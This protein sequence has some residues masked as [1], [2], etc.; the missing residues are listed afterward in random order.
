MNNQAATLGRDG[1][2]CNSR[3]KT[4]AVC[5]AI[6]GIT[7]TILARVVHRRLR[8][9]FNSVAIIQ[10]GKIVLSAE[11]R[12]KNGRWSASRFSFLRRRVPAALPIFRRSGDSQMTN[13][14]LRC[15]PAAPIFFLAFDAGLLQG[16]HAQTYSF[17]LIAA[18]I[19]GTH[20]RHASPEH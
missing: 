1:N 19:R 8:I 20:N 9:R 4:Y 17:A 5:M 14:F 10:V 6:P 12:S 18:R 15:S 2:L 16:S 13:D 3:E 7:Q 11:W